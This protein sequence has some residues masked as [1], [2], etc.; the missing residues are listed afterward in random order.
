[1][2]VVSL[3]STVFSPPD[4]KASHGKAGENKKVVSYQAGLPTVDYIPVLLEKMQNL[5]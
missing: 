1:M 2:E 3:Q 5:L 4:A